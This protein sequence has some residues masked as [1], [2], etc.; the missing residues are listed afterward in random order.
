MTDNYYEILQIP[1]DADEREIKSAYHRLARELHPDKAT[2]PEDA[3]AFEERFAE[4]SAAYNAL[5]DPVKRAEFDKRNQGG[6]AARKPAPPPP[7]S[8]SF[9]PRKNATAAVLS[10]GRGVPPPQSA[11]SAPAQPRPHL[12]LTPEKAAIAQKA[13]ARGMQFFKEQNF[14]QAIDFFEAAIQ[15]N[16]TE[17][18]YHARLAMALIQARKS[19]TRALDAAQRAIDLEPY[20]LD[21]KFNM[22]FIFEMIGSKTNA[23][24]IYEEILRWD[25]GNARA[26]AALSALKKNKSSIAFGLGSD[27]SE[28]PSFLQQIFSRFRK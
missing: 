21:Y 20:N 2:S 9:T 26:T 28:K 4:V 6:G 22:A 10:A 5:K 17:G 14:S 7:A 24:K 13:F 3:K 8:S 18:V 27:D 19:G 25:A 1:S 15:N 16:E 12:G 23:K 11:A